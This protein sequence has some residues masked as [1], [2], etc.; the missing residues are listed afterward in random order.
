MNLVR[1]IYFLLVASL[2]YSC[3]DPTAVGASLLEE[4]R[5][6]VGFVDTFS[7]S[8]RTTKRDSVR[9]YSPFSQGQL[10]NFLLGNFNDPILGRSSA[11]INAQL[12]PTTSEPGFADTINGIDSLI[13][14]LPYNV[15][16]PIR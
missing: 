2:I 1:F 9:V 14:F 12:F 11:S 13:L 16:G 4:D 10:T 3:N 5:A 7:V 6:E 8:A 15:L